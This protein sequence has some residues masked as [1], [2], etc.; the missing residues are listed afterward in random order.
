MN[1]DVDDHSSAWY[2][3]LQSTDNNHNEIHGELK[4]ENT[5][6]ISR[7][8]SLFSQTAEC[9]DFGHPESRRFPSLSAQLPDQSL[10]DI[11]NQSYQTE[12]SP[13]NSS[14]LDMS[15]STSSKRFSDVKR[16]I[17]NFKIPNRQP[18]CQRPHHSRF[19][20][21]EFS[22]LETGH[23]AISPTHSTCSALNYNTPPLTPDSF[24]GTVNSAC[25]EGSSDLYSRID[26]HQ[27]YIDSNQRG[28][29]IHNEDNNSHH[30]R[31]L[32]RSQE[33]KEGKK[34]ERPI[35]CM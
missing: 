3:S 28:I 31:Q 1:H 8:R 20:S 29:H 14:F 32:S 17:S 23:T 13:L 33:I 26:S 35:V 12:P 4:D 15:N 27:Q 34:P 5:N 2:P 24:D 7:I 21:A 22:C 6:I 9:N 11:C 10:L 19:E 25:F 18:S 30:I 16:I